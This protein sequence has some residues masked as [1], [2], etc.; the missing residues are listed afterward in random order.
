[1]FSHPSKVKLVSGAVGAGY[2]VHLHIMIVPVEL[3]VQRVTER[4]RRGGH[5]VPEE[6]ICARDE[7]VWAHLATAIDVADVVDVFDNGSA[8]IPFRPCARFTHGTLIGPASWPKW[9]PNRTGSPS[10]RVGPD[11]KI[12]YLT[13][14]RRP[15]A[16]SGTPDLALSRARGS[17]VIKDRVQ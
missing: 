7:R 15:S 8:R 4:V 10:G 16:C 9:A 12:T 3:A 14:H 5:A 17:V 2:L 11:P 6:K 1:M 13:R